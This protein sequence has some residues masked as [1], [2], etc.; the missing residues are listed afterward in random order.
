M[1]KSIPGYEKL[2]EA[3]SNTGQIRS[4]DRIIKCPYRDDFRYR[5]RKSKILKPSQDTNGYHQVKLCNNTKIQQT[6]SVH[7]LILF[8]FIGLRPTGYE[9]NHK[10]GIK[11]D[12]RLSNLEYCS[13]KQNNVH[14]LEVLKHNP[15]RK[16]NKEN[17]NWIRQNHIKYNHKDI[18]I[19]FMVSQ[20]TIN[21][22]IN[23]KI[24]NSEE[25]QAGERLY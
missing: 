22:I 1:W 11:T 13:T 3:N 19:M 15:N 8:V 21:R 2:Y 6:Y 23:N 12:N 5:L 16:L 4:L 20:S 17:I 14:A 7:C 10:N 18:A 25:F 9:I 24:Y